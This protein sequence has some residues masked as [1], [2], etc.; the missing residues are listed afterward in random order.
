MFLGC[1]EPASEE[2]GSHLES[3]DEPLVR[4][5]LQHNGGD[6]L[7]CTCNGDKNPII[8]GIKKTIESTE[9]EEDIVPK[10][11]A[12]SALEDGEENEK[13]VELN[14]AED[15]EPSASEQD[16]AE[17]AEQNP[18]EEEEEDLQDEESDSSEEQD[19][20]EAA[21]K[22]T[23]EEE[24][25]KESKKLDEDLVEESNSSEDNV[26]AADQETPEEEDKEENLEGEE[27]T[28]STGEDADLESEE[29]SVSE[30]EKGEEAGGETM[31][32]EEEKD[33]SEEDTDT[34]ESE[35][36]QQPDVG[37]GDS[38]AEV[39]EVGENLAEAEGD[40]ATDASLGS[41]EQSNES[42]SL[43]REDETDPE[44][45]GEY[46]KQDEVGQ[47]S[48][49]A[50]EPLGDDPNADR[51]I[52]D[53]ERLGEAPEDNQESTG[54]QD[55]DNVQDSSHDQ[56]E[57]QETETENYASDSKG[58][59]SQEDDESEE[60]LEPAE[61]LETQEEA[62]EGQGVKQEG[63]EEQQ[64][65]AP[66]DKSDSVE[67]EKEGE[68]GSQESEED[69]PETAD[70][71]DSEDLSDQ[72]ESPDDKEVSDLQ[73]V[74]PE[75]E[76]EEADS[77]ESSAESIET[78]KDAPRFQEEKESGELGQEGGLPVNGEAG[79]E[80]SAGETDPEDVETATSDQ[81]AT[82][83]S[84]EE[85]NEEG[86]EIEASIVD[87]KGDREGPQDADVKP[88]PG[89]TTESEDH[90]ATQRTK[91]KM[92]K[93]R[94]TREEE[95]ELLASLLRDR[96]HI[97]ETLRLK[98]D[99]K[100]D[101]YSAALQ[102]L[103]KIYH[104]AIKPLEQA[105]RYNEL[106]QHE[107]S[108]H[109]Y[110]PCADSGGAKMNTRC[111][112]K[113]VPSAA[114]FFTHYE[115]TVQ[116]P[117][118]YSVGGQRSSGQLTGKPAGARP[119]YRGRWCAVSRGHP[120]R[121]NPPSPWAT[122]G[123]LSAAPWKLPSTVGCGIA[124]TRTGDVQ[125]MERILHS[126]ECFYWMRHSGA[127]TAFISKLNTQE[128]Y[129]FNDVCQWFIDHADL[130]F[131]IFDPTKLDVGLELETLFRQLKG[132]ESQIRIILN[133]ADS[134]VTQDLMRVYGALFWSLAP[135]INVTEPPRV[136]VSSFWPLDYAADT[137][138]ELFKKEEISLLEDLN[139]VIENRL[140]NKIAFIRQHGIRVRIH[141]LLVD[142][143][144][145]TYR[146][147]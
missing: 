88:E 98:E 67:K 137:S 127:P 116:P 36:E 91:S 43:N 60:N 72:T 71:R 115:L 27:S 40:D 147:R 65:P 84:A 26:E 11:D 140:E 18:S 1:Q 66:E 21:E 75:G 69:N 56:V 14:A 89:D 129:P 2:V 111:P 31:S 25:D 35:E 130:I 50:V 112:P 142:R 124:W 32:E 73:D 81:P 33:A 9:A 123:Q 22:N 38:T 122:L 125:A 80:G 13:N 97:E 29:H 145:Q 99:T 44:S 139:Q 8:N 74:S 100:S 24:D 76:E 107:I 106:R 108:A 5:Q 10:P 28:T 102:R 54:E 34:S 110:H 141:A 117:Q 53:H 47:A 126:S 20:E 83:E 17:D 41:E 135:L 45:E 94:V 113:R 4:L 93:S 87:E 23:S 96:S 16:S 105:Y 138:R 143:Y 57:L 42:E 92:P 146:V 68:G 109:R 82:E 58:D 63:E 61:D 118:S 12:V 90:S 78:E 30:E 144:L 86:E 55:E 64:D 37:E 39:T 95:D 59:T 62:E 6:L 48:Y 134:L 7:M 70:E 85:K 51:S 119:D 136:Y 49:E 121:P 52:Q 132:R 46:E 104:S 3:H 114:R 103:R 19:E 133:K 131:V 79:E 128:C 120:G 101:D 77:E 15:G